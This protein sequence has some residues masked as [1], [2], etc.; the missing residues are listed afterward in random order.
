[1]FL[2]EVPTLKLAAGV[3]PSAPGRGE[4]G[5]PELLRKAAVYLGRLGSGPY[6]HLNGGMPIPI[7]PQ[8]LL[9]FKKPC[10]EVPC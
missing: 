6:P 8:T 2:G 10:L 5:M 3:R 4:T 1:M 9:E 7:R